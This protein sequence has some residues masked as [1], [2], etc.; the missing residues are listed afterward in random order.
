[1]RLGGAA[2]LV[3]AAALGGCAESVTTRTG[4]LVGSGPVNDFAVAMTSVQELRFHTV[5]HQQYDFS[6]GSAAL[7]TLLRF[8][9]AD[10]VDEQKVFLGM[11]AEGDKPAIRQVGF[12]LLD[13]KRYLQA[14]GLKADGYRVSLDQIEKVAVPGIALV[15]IGSYRHFVVVKGVRPDEVLLGD[16]SVGLRTMPRDEFQQVWNGVYFVLDPDQNRGRARFNQGAQ[17]ASFA[18]A[19]AGGIFLDP[20]SLQALSLTA[21]F[22]RDF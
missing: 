8:H 10:P 19:P 3:A 4:F 9:Y 14:R 20:V 13:M 5:V 12:S 1:M 18:R 17:W 11:W 15:T 21:P 2:V 7:A 6:C 16:P 22:Y